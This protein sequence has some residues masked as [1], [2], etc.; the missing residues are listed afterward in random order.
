MKNWVDGIAETVKVI[1][2]D[3]TS[4]KLQNEFLRAGAAPAGDE[5]VEG[6]NAGPSLAARAR[7]DK[8]KSRGS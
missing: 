2:A 8:Q 6:G 7:D 4:L 5:A 3:E 1:K